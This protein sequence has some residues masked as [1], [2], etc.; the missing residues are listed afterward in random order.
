M[1][2]IRDAIEY[3][4]SADYLHKFASLARE[5]NASTRV[6]L[7]ETWH[8]VNDPEGWRTRLEKDRR[9]LL[10]RRHI[11]ARSGLR[12]TTTANLCYSCGAGILQ[13]LHAR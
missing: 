12:R 2:E 3:F 7:Y 5:G 9:P 13:K 6:Y 1:V 8:N 4:D 10:G 11:A